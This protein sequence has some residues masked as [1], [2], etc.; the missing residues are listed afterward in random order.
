MGYSLFPPIRAKE[1]EISKQDE[2][3]LKLAV[4]R[5]DAVRLA[6]SPFL[7]AISAQRARRL[8]LANTYFDTPDGELGR[9]QMS[10]R[11]RTVGRRRIQT[12]KTPANKT[13]GMQHFI[14]FESDV[15]GETPDIEK[16]DDEKL[17]Q[18]LSALN[19]TKGLQQRFSTRFTRST[20]VVRYDGSDIEVCV[21]QGAIEAGERRQTISE[22]ELELIAGRPERLPKLA[23]ELNK[24]IPLRTETRSKANRANALLEGRRPTPLKAGKVA[25]SNKQTL[26]DAFQSVA[27]SCLE[28]I[29][30]N[31][32]AVLDGTDSEG[33]HQLRIGL[34]R[35]LTALKAFRPV[36]KSRRYRYLNTTAK[37]AQS[38]FGPARDWDV[39][40]ETTLPMMRDFTD[41]AEM[42]GWLDVKSRQMHEKAYKQAHAMITDP[43]YSEFVLRLTLWLNTGGFIADKKAGS[44]GK[45]DLRQLVGDVLSLRDRKMRKLASKAEGLSHIQLHRLRLRAKQ[46]RYQAEYFR[47]LFGKKE[48]RRFIRTVVD[49]Q[50]C[51][52]SL[53]DA[54]VAEH[55]M[56]DLAVIATA[57]GD[58]PM[59]DTARMALAGHMERKIAKDLRQFSQINQ[60]YLDTESFWT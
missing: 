27:R 50:D 13:A 41:R 10:L 56:D 9:N 18:Y 23:L 35:L 52:G 48:V 37:W 58:K 25:L 42:I 36:L 30:G 15:T 21:D 6:R 29:R 43:R 38:Q 39:F 12:L 45:G 8:S 14:E 47:D 17:R 11:I 16:I 34:R 3:E 57:R 4:S 44:G 1:G 32:A 49:I 22:V 31:E 20:R 46:M 26:E 55:L 33:V 53:N 2:I 40:R 54:V 19:E 60:R 5:Q 7:R 51:L 28:Q 24:R 59:L